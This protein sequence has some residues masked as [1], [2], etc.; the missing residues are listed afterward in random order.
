MACPFVCWVVRNPGWR[1]CQASPGYVT[2]RMSGNF[3]VVSVGAKRWVR[4]YVTRLVLAFLQVVWRTGH[5][6][7]SNREAFLSRR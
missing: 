1:G 4:R 2:G 5:V 6:I 3:D 7:E